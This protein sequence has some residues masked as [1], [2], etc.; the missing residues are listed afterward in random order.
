MTAA[1]KG[2]HRRTDVTQ[3]GLE[4][5][6]FWPRLPSQALLATPAKLNRVKAMVL[7]DN[8][9]NPSCVVN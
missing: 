7:T 4:L 1:T 6:L 3:Q 2:P 5:N 8:G 9:F